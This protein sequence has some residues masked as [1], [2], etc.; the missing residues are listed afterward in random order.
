MIR[1]LSDIELEQASGGFDLDGFNGSLSGYRDHLD[2]SP[3]RIGQVG[4]VENSVSLSALTAIAPPEPTPRAE[5]TP[6]TPSQTPELGN[7]ALP[8]CLDQG[9][10]YAICQGDGIHERWERY[11]PQQPSFRSRFINR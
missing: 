6:I 1:N 7:L 2:I 10:P 4:D 3:Y 8:I 9:G 11:R 5:V